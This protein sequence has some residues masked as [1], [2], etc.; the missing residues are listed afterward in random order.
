A[1][2]LRDQGEQFDVI[3]SDIEMPGMTGFDFAR[4]VKETGR[5]QETPLIAL[6]SHTTTADLAKG[7]EAGFDDYVAKHDR[8]ALL[9]TLNDIGGV[10]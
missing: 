5:W 4:A 6:S 9:G 7:R 8:D 1:L 2:L 3:I 10:A